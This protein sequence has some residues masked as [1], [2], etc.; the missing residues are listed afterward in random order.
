MHEVRKVLA[1]KGKN[2]K[3]ISKTKNHEGVRRFD[4]ILEASDG[5]MVAR[6]D[7]G[8]EISAEKVFQAQKTMIGQCNRAG[9]PVI[10]A[11]QMLESMIKKPHP[12]RAE[13]SNVANPV[14]DG[15]DFIMLSRETANGNYS[16]EAVRLQHLIAG[17]AE[18]AIYHLKLFKELR[19]LTPITSDPTEAATVGTMETSFKCCS[20]AIIVLN[21]SARRA[22]QVAR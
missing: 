11:T 16:L 12:T 5:I 4:E 19:C 21:K 17:D 14:L 15:A 3:I 1:D 2:I 13:G 20:R 6:D 8:I 10:C 7:L 18:A 22:H 9:E